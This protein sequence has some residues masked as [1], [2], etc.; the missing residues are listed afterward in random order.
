MKTS[1]DI[2][3]PVLNEEVTLRSKVL[4]L[5]TYLVQCLNDIEWQII[6]A[7]NGSTDTTPAISEELCQKYP[8]IKYLRVGERGVGLAL[9]KSWGGSKSDIIACMDL[10]LSTDIRHVPEAMSAIV[11]KGCDLVYASRL[12]KD[13]KVS[14]R[15]FKRECT[16]R[17]FNFILKKYLNVKISDGMCGF[18]FLKRKNFAV[19]QA[20]GAESN[21]WFFQA[22][23]LVISEWLGHKIFELPVTWID[24]PDSKVKVVSVAMEYLKSMKV[25]RKK[26]K[27]IRSNGTH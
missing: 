26:M 13:A 10:D 20:N 11:N 8:E 12:H 1:L 18:I 5:H 3:I 4:E 2:T 16:S 14:G 19:L 9:K 7:D 25:L 22:E 27:L 6:I 15:S 17:A 23:V 21:R 24:D